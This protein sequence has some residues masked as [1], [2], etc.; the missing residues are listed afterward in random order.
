MKGNVSIGPASNTHS[1][2]L[3]YRV[4]YVG[5]NAS[6]WD[7]WIVNV[8]ASMTNVIRSSDFT[9]RDQYNGSQHE[10]TVSVRWE[11]LTFPAALVTASL[12]YLLVIIFQTAAS[13]V[14]S[15]KESP[16]TMLLFE[17]HRNISHEAHGQVEEQGGLLKT[18]GGTKIRMSR[19]DGGI[20]KLHAC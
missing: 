16:L 8:A 7:P 18:I 13:P 14:Y 6:A 15:W 9:S 5:T 12:M 17:L 20:R 11:W 4:W 10:L 2:D 1:S 19:E 3:I